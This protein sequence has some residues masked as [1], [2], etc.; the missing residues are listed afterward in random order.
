MSKVLK[1]LRQNAGVSQTDVMR[2]LGYDT[3]QF[4]SN[5]ER[6]IS[7]PPI[8]KI[9]KLAKLY[10]T[11]ADYLYTV[12]KDETIA[13]TVAKLNKAWKRVNK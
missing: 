11:D 12:V 8:S 4:I 5:W 10:G 7:L 6:G 13:R 2:A 3:P 1:T 9:K